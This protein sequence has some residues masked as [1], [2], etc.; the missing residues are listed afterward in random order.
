[1][2]FVP[3]AT[4]TLLA[5]VVLFFVVTFLYALPAMV[6]EPPAGATAEWQNERIKARLAGK[7]HWFFAGSALVV[8]VVMSRRSSR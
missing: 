2:R 5:T 3:R 6:E 1:V 4:L 8:A 7:V